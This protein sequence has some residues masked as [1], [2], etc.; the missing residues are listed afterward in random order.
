[1]D[2][3]DIAIAAMALCMGGL[4]WWATTTWGKVSEL[5]RTSQ[6]KSDCQC[7]KLSDELHAFREK[8]VAEYLREQ[9]FLEYRRE[10]K[11]D[12][13]N[14]FNKIHGTLTEIFQQLKEL[15]K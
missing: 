1:M 13:E 3:K 9:R 2:W 5:E 6:P 8:V 4:G 10:L 15:R 12:M 11:A 14:G 7:P